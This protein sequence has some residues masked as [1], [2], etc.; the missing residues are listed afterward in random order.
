MSPETKATLTLLAVVI[1]ILVGTAVQVVYGYDILGWMFS[2]ALLLGAI[3]G[4]WYALRA[5]YRPT[6]RNNPHKP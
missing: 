1:P 5:A 4:L 6:K 3:V 2:I